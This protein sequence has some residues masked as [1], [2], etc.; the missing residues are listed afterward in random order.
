MKVLET[1]EVEEE[2]RE[3]EEGTGKQ[4]EILWS[5]GDCAN[6]T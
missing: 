6:D 2:G 3:E 1:V 5:R 4:G